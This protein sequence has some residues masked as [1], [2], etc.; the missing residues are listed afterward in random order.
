MM[1]PESRK[2][3][4][5]SGRGFTLIE[6]LVAIAILMLSVAGPL[7]AADRAI[8]AASIARDQLTAS[9][10]AQE[11]IEHVRLLRDNAYLSQYKDNAASAS[12]AGWGDFQSAIEGQCLMSASRVCSVDTSVAPDRY[13]FGPSASVYTC[14]STCA[15]LQYVDN[16]WAPYTQSSG[17]AT[18]RFTRTLQV[19]P[20]TSSDEY[21][22]STV[23]W[24][25]RGTTY[26]VKITDHLTPWQ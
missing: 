24:N 21:I 4:A 5:E 22:V 8:V 15:P 9:Y 16:I 3:K 25:Y 13:G 11:A 6:S 1:N 14:G 7:Y 17:G 18:T 20:V 26:T 10:L 23:T 19:S 12:S 2:Q